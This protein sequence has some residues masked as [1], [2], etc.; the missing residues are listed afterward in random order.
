M[1]AAR[2]R[3]PFHSRAEEEQLRA[4]KDNPPQEEQPLTAPPLP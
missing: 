4:L 3:S 1:P 2:G